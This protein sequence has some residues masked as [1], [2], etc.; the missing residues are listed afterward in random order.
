MHR[1]DYK[2]TPKKLLTPSIVSQIA[3]LHEYKGKQDLYISA[4][5][6]TLSALLEI[7]KIRI[8]SLDASV[9]TQYF[10]KCGLPC[11]KFSM[12]CYLCVCGKI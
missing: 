12:Y 8:K 6:D 1:F 11:R 7:A 10:P 9:R 4:Q 3:A 2:D 5:V